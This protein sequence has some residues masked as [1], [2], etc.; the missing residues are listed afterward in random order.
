M[1]K[2][3]AKLMDDLMVL[4]CKQFSM[5][6]ASDVPHRPGLYG[7]LQFWTHWGICS[8]CRAYLRAIKTIGNLHRKNSTLTQYLVERM[9]AFKARLRLALKDRAR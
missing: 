2:L 5:E 1:A 9:P 3:T 7:R 8:S 4:T 6:V